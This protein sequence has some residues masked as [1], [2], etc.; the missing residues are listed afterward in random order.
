MQTMMLTDYPKRAWQ[1]LRRFWPF[2]ILLALAGGWVWFAIALS[3]AQ[4]RLDLP[5]AYGVQMTCE[6][7]PEADLWS[8]GCD[9][10]AADIAKDGYP[11]LLEL[12]RAFSVVHHGPSPREQALRLAAASAE[13][14]FDLDAALKGQ[15]YGLALERPAFEG[16]RSA[17]HAE[18]VKAA[19][20]ER[21]R[22]LLVIGR[23]G[24][25]V[26]PLVAGAVANLLH[27]GTMIRSAGIYVDVLRGT[28]KHSDLVTGQA[29]QR[30]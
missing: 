15:R 5:R 21:D 29:E 13:P 6:D 2:V 8:G 26:P 23:A 17:E 18:A 19:I 27:P 14:G 25:T 24:L 22:A 28:A 7:D 3:D 11:T 9:R 16:V 10:I 20:D 1:W 12:Y 4:G 30:Q